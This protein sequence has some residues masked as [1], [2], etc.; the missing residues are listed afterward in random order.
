VTFKATLTP[1]LTSMDPKYATVAGGPTLT[2]T[3]TGFSSTTS[4]NTVIIDGVACAVT[5]ST[6]TTIT[7]TT[8]SRTGTP[9]ASLEINVN[10]KGRV[11]TQGLR[12]IYGR[13]WSDINTWGGGFPP[14]EG[15]SLTIQKGVNM[16]VDIDNSP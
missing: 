10:N 14:I 8:G 1:T 15:D 7:C 3:G 9:E 6:D 4:D 16:I 11:A 12:F 13:Y 2:L 5:A